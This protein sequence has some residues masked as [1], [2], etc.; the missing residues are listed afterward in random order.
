MSAMDPGGNLR[1]DIQQAL[2]R[3][4]LTDWQRE[5]LTDIHS[6]LERSNGQA[7][8]S[9]KQWRKVFEI[10]G[11]HA[12]VKTVTPLIRFNRPSRPMRTWILQSRFRGRRR[13]LSRRIERLA[14]GLAI[15][16]I[17]AIFQLFTGSWT[18]QGWHGPPRLQQPQL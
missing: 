18:Q 16:A 13:Y 15:V 17:L 3:Q 7:R 14:V 5:F 12:A 4:R 1:S 2:S 9:D 10:L 6:R 11:R 8:L